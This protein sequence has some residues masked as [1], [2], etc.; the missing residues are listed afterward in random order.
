MNS[1]NKNTDG[2]EQCSI[3]NR[4]KQLIS[5]EELIMKVP[6]YKMTMYLAKGNLWLS[7]EMGG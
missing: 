5:V 2:Y 7:R 6:M 1:E 3:D 4:I